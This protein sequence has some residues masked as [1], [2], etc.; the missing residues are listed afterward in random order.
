MGDGRGHVSI[1]SELLRVWAPKYLVLFYN[2]A[3]KHNVM[4]SLEG[5]NICFTETAW[6]RPRIYSNET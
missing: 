2:P 5:I 4:S 6:K 1:G 3:C